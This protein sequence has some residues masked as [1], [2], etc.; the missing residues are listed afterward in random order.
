MCCLQAVGTN[1]EPVTRLSF[2]RAR[3]KFLSLIRRNPPK[4]RKLPEDDDMLVPDGELASC[5]GILV[6]SVSPEK[7]LFL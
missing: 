3:Q 7:S 1:T 6:S 2:Q 4:Q 5:F